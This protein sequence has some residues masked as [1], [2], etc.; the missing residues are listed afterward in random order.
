MKVTFLGST[1]GYWANMQKASGDKWAP[2][3]DGTASDLIE[4]A[5]RA[6]YQSWGRPNPETSTN[7]GYLANIINQQ[8]FSVLEHGTV[9][10]Y[11]EDVSRSLTHELVRHRHFSFS[12]LSQRYVELAG[13]DNYV[14]PPL[15]KDD[16][17]AQAVLHQA[18]LSAT[19]AYLALEA[20]A[21]ATLAE[22]GVTGLKA[23]KM[24]REAARAVLP[25]MTPTAIVVTGNHR[26]WRE[27]LEKRGT[28][29]ADAEIRWLALE[30][31]DVLKVVEPNVYQDFQVVNS[32]T[33]VLERIPG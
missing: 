12:Q 26:S 9:T 33:A 8:H 7:P 20:Q 14:V 24:A 13:D 10:V 31:F 25:N 27:F 23:R 28:I 21:T 1:T 16:V 22:R 29:H 15:F 18:W 3:G 6:C 19:R 5:G 17:T 32:G 30:M 11:I 4:F 2:D